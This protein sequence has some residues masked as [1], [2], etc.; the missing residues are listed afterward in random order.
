MEE[1]ENKKN[2]EIEVIDERDLREVISE[3][4]GKACKKELNKSYIRIGGAAF[5]GTAAAIGLRML[6]K[7]IFHI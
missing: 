1:N 5:A 3:E 7:A 2:E 6:V 4:A